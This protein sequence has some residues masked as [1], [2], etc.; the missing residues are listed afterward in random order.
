MKERKFGFTFIII[1]LS[2]LLITINGVWLTI[3]KKPII[4]S[5]FP[6][7]SVEEILDS[8]AFWGRIAFGF[9]GVVENFAILWIIPV[10]LMSLCAF[11]IHK[12][13]RSQKIYG[14]LVPIFAILALPFGGGFYIGTIIGF[15]AGIAGV[16]WPKPFKETFFGYIASAA[17]LNSK[18]FS[19]VAGSS[20]L[21]NKGALT[22]ALVGLLTG[23]GSG[24]YSYNANLIKQEETA[25]N[26]ILMNGQVMWHQTVAITAISLIMVTLV[27][28]LILSGCIYWIG[29]KLTG[30]Q[31][32][33][34]TVAQTLAF[35]YVPVVLEAFMPLVFSNEP[36]LSFAWPVGLYTISR[37]LFLIALVTAIGKIFDL[38]RKKAL[39]VALFSGSIYW[40]IVHTIII[41][42]YNVP[43]VHII[44]SLPNSS[45]AILFAG[46]I[47][48]IVSVMLGVFSKK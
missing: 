10:I 45:P 13:P 35:C 12:H 15:I 43:G 11:K 21:L 31:S 40:I 25:A 42:A 3:N 39:G 16:E 6:A 44:L 38:T 5:S 36:V 32:T 18:F 48:A 22:V 1:V 28:W 33:Y 27:K 19:A 29:A 24:L 7:N 23:I 34:S 14:F 4:I 20:N 37:L 9:S 41:P 2:V 30:L 8:E 17:R 46:G 26:Q 47:I